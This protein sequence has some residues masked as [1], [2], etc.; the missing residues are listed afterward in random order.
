MSKVTIDDIAYEMMLETENT[1]SLPCNWDMQSFDTL[2]I[3]ESL[4]IASGST[5]TQ[6]VTDLLDR[7][8]KG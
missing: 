5:H 1:Q 6:Q 8:M 7:L 2:L 3:F 4:L